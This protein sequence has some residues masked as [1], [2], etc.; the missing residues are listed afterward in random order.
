MALWY[1]TRATGVVALLLVTLTLVLGVLDVG[2]F[3]WPRLPRFAIDAIHRSASLLVIV[4]VAVHVLTAVIDSY[5][6]VRLADAVVP[7]GGTYRPLWVGLGALSFDLLLALVIT[8]LL[9]A[10]L[11]VRAWRIVHWAAY[12]CWPLA[13]LHGLGTGSDVKPGWFLWL[14]IACSAVVAL[15]IL[16]R[17]P[18]GIAQVSV[19]TALAVGAL[20]LAVW[21][22]TGPLGSG[23]AA[24]AGTPSALLHGGAR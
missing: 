16:S 20:G 7:F 19:V 12:A 8:S 2:R 23:W 13:L 21:L 24:K 15:A 5:A 18:K 22:P 10:R 11:G 6:P 17:A 1:L 14:S 9:R 4:F 3:S